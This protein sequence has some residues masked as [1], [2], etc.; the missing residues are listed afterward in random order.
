MLVNWWYTKA[1]GP[2]R[3]YESEC[4]THPCTLTGLPF[5]LVVVPRLLNCSSSNYERRSDLRSPPSRL[6]L[7]HPSFTRDW[8]R[9]RENSLPPNWTRCEKSSAG[10][11]SCLWFR[12]AFWKASIKA[13]DVAAMS[14]LSACLNSLSYMKNHFPSKKKKVAESWIISWFSFMYT[15][16]MGFFIWLRFF[17]VFFI[18]LVKNLNLLTDVTARISLASMCI[19][20]LFFRF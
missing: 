13:E 8:S 20:S 16:T 9:W 15:F 12:G 19:Y 3:C 10:A 17:E 14:F 5:Q 18:P 6:F 4:S 1:S 11:D 7:P 2:W